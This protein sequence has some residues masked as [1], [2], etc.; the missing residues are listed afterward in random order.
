[1]NFDL[2][3]VKIGWKGN[4]SG[5]LNGSGADADISIFRYTGNLSAPT[6]VGSAAT[7]SG[8]MAS[9]W[10]LVGNYA[11]LST[12]SAK[13]VNS[14]D[15][16]SSWWMISA[17]NSSFGTAVND[18]GTTT[19]MS[20]VNATVS[21]CSTNLSNANDY[22]KVLSIAG[23]ATPKPPTGVPEPGSIALLGLGLVGI[24]AARRRK[25]APL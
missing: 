17:Y 20:Q 14:K 7:G 11:D 16:T 12:S 6:P 22:F 2:N 10:E 24:A 25:Q 19:C 15:K 8:L 9:G 21:G 4:S 13:S 5:V 18:T 23:I 1:M 3:S